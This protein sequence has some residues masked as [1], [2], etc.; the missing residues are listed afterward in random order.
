[1]KLTTPQLFLLHDVFEGVTRTVSVTYKPA[2]R[3]QELGLVTLAAGRTCCKI[4][5]TDAGRAEAKELFG[6]L[7]EAAR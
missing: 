5:L 6:D 4:M 1:V 2:L 3:L 7:P